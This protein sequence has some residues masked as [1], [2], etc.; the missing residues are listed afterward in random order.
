[1]QWRKLTP[2]RKN[3]KDRTSKISSHGHR[4]RLRRHLHGL[5]C[6][7][8]TGRVSQKGLTSRRL[9]IARL[10]RRRR[11]RRRQRVLPPGRGI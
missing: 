10:A 1:M 4:G 2:T 9:F 5:K 7:H 11:R 3:I 6:G 8:G